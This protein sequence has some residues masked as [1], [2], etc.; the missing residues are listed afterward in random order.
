M[1]QPAVPDSF[2]SWSEAYEWLRGQ[3]ED[4]GKTQPTGSKVDSNNSLR[5]LCEA[6][7]IR[8][9]QVQEAIRKGKEDR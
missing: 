2:A 3:V 9:T 4:L 8:T 6:L 7:G 1:N 5:L